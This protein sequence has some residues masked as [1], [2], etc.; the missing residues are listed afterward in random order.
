MIEALYAL[1]YIEDA[2]NTNLDQYALNSNAPQTLSDS[3]CLILR[4][5]G[6]TMAVFG[7]NTIRLTGITTFVAVEAY[8]YWCNKKLDCNSLNISKKIE[9]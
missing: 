3:T 1:T 4:I 9:L 8:E 6:A 2:I 7:K 5:T